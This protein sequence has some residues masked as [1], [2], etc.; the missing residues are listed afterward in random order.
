MYVI[1]HRNDGFHYLIEPTAPQLSYSHHS[2]NNQNTCIGTDIHACYL[3]AELRPNKKNKCV[4]G[5]GSEN[6]R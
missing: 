4:L 3:D 1:W 6:F 5:N 2:L